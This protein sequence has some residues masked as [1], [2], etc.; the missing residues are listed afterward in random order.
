MAA[1]VALVAKSP[2]DQSF[3]CSSS[4]S[5]SLLH[6]GTTVPKSIPYSACFYL[7]MSCSYMIKHCCYDNSLVFSYSF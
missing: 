1:V 4:Q 6:D 2:P 7:A 5:C 3:P